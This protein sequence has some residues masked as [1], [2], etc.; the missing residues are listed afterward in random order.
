[1]RPEKKKNDN[2]ERKK[3]T[4]LYWIEMRKKNKSNFEP[5]FF[6][7]CCFCRVGEDIDVPMFIH[8]HFRFYWKFD[9]LIC[10]SICLKCLYV[11]IVCVCVCIYWNIC[12]NISFSFYFFFCFF[13]GQTLFAQLFVWR[14]R[15]RRLS[16]F[17]S[18]SSWS[19]HKHNGKFW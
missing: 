11:Y 15:R 6:L 16:S 7:G 9:F 8:H 4:R 14:R 12:L 10:M 3:E 19:L 1:M 13:F 18:T 2:K 5:L 17:T